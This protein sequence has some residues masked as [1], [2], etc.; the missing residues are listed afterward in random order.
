MRVFDPKNYRAAMWSQ[1]LALLELVSVTQSVIIHVGS[2]I[3][4]RSSL[5]CR[6]LCCG[7]PFMSTVRYFSTAR[8]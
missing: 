8:Y 6:V 7:L 3:I 1:V 4:K 2:S 5:S